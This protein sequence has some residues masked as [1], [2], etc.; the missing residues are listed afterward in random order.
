MILHSSFH[1]PVLL[2]EV[3]SYLNIRKDGKYIDATLGGGGFT[4]AILS[5]GGKVLGIDCDREAVRE[6]ERKF[7][8]GGD[9]I[10]VHDN[11][12]NIHVIAEKNNFLN[13]DGVIFDLGL[14]SYQI[15]RSGR[16]FT[17]RQDEP[18]DMRADA[19]RESL[20]AADIINKFNQDELY[21][22]FS[23][24]SEE[25]HSR[26]IAAAIVRAR[27]LNAKKKAIFTTRQLAAVIRSVVEEQSQDCLEMKR[28]N[29]TT[30]R[31]FQA[32]RIEVNREMLNLRE[33][34]TDAIRILTAG[35]RIAVI[36]YHSGE[37]RTVKR[38]FE[39]GIKNRDI[40]Y[41]SKNVIVPRYEEKKRN[42]RSRS[43][44]LRV[45]EKL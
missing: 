26:A 32:L 10:I 33:G 6:A 28:V 38:I 43:A 34:I 21:E 44:K 40:R 2:P 29:E 20:T 18:L 31:I 25:I 37:D 8:T 22:V 16:G 4:D 27:A 12:R 5:R 42:S 19:E 30:A 45:A 35:G 24:N 11:F 36:S 41:I 39:Q 23:R 9:L 13:A 15:D 1:S 17:F 14:S 7:S 3:I